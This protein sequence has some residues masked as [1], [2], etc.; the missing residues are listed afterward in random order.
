[1]D[2]FWV[3]Q[4]CSNRNRYNVYQ[5]ESLLMSIRE[6]NYAQW[7]VKLHIFVAPV[8]SINIKD[9]R[10]LN[11]DDRVPDYTLKP[12]PGVRNTICPHV[13]QVFDDRNQKI[14]EVRY[15]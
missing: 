2:S 7:N 8:G 6:A 13:L 15:I 5:G 12:A 4:T 10:E 3:N 11:E 9:H 1:M 14:A